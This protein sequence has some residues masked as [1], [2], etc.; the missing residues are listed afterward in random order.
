M[1]KYGILEEGEV[2]TAY[3]TLAEVNGRDYIELVEN[4]TWEPSD[5]T[6][7]ETGINY[8]EAGKM[9]KMFDDLCHAT[10]MKK[11]ALAQIC[12]KH[13]TS[14]SGYTSGKTPVPRLVWE[15]VSEFKK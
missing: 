3:T 10:G 5:Y 6:D 12:G 7:P 1:K 14:F 9:A 13:V 15:K 11:K 8:I 2:L 4:Y